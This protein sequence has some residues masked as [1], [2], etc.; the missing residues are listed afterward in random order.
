MFLT[1]SMKLLICCAVG[2]VA[3]LGQGRTYTKSQITTGAFNHESPSLNNR[4]D[5]VWSQ[6]V[7]GFWQVY[8]LPSGSSAPVRLGGQASDHNNEHPT[9][10]DAGRVLYL[11][12][13]VGQGVARAVILNNGGTESVI[14]F[15]SRNN[16]TGQHRDA[17]QHFGIASNGTTIS[18]YDFLQFGFGP[19]RFN[20]SG[21]GQIPGD[22]SGKDFPDINSNGTFVYS[23]FGT[24][25]SA[26]VS[27]AGSPLPIASGDRPRIADIVPPATVPEIVYI[28]GSQVLSTIGGVIDV[29]SWADVNNAGTVVYEKA[30][31]GFNQI[32]LATIGSGGTINV[33]TN[34]PAATF[35]VTGP[36]TFNG[37]GMSFTQANAPVGVYTATFG[38]VPSFVTPSQQVRTLV[39]NGTI[40]FTG[41]YTACEFT[42]SPATG[43]F[44]AIGGTGNFDVIASGSTCNWA[45]STF[46]P[47]I[48]ITSASIGMGNGTIRYTVSSYTGAGTRTGTITVAGQTFSV[49]QRANTCTVVQPLTSIDDLVQDPRFADATY[50]P[51]GTRTR[52]LENSGGIDEVDLQPSLYNALQQFRQA[53][54]RQ[55]GGHFNLQSAFRTKAYQQHLREVYD[56]KRALDALIDDHPECQDLYD[57]VNRE[58]AS[59]ANGGVHGLGAARPGDPLNPNYR[60]HTTGSAID[61]GLNQSGLPLQ[62]LINLAC[63]ANL[64]RPLL[65][66]DQ[67][68]FELRP[69]TSTRCQ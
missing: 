68:H 51:N 54:N 11:K 36:A 46:D 52:V 33:T 60:R 58:F 15:S 7:S 65:P 62:Q 23:S 22:F 55:A 25:F 5:V 49:V 37:A 28:G 35:T 2:G 24:V 41:M 12:D 57:K 10:D 27:A 43:P 59:P 19:R 30:V 32:F 17:G 4:G 21:A 67:P 34:M 66:G 26:A 6:Q 3:T 20:V 38:N 45:A 42:L 40:T 13:G 69:S 44:G 16:L 29:G 39:A 14:E 48:T 63:S 61:V 53:V 47:W 9:I 8:V 31:T 18:Y 56:K 64:Y 1:R 50:D